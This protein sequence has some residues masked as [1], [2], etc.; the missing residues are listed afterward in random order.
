MTTF[1]FS[2]LTAG[3]D[4]MAQTDPH[5]WT[6]TIISVTV[7]FLALIVLYFLY[8]L[9]GK[10]FTGAF[11]RKPSTKKKNAQVPDAEVAAAIALALDMEEDGD[12]YA[13]IAAAIHLYLASGIHD[14]EPGIV[15]IRRK[16]SPWSNKA[17]T[18]RKL[19]R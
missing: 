5:G 2:I 4:R 1:L 13:A 11:K 17:L 10:I 15:T 7:V 19:P 9:S 18:F 12:S 3:S 8:N 16:D 14:T 6:L